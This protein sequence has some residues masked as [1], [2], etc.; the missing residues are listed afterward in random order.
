MQ[1]VSIILHG[2]SSSGKTS[3]A[4]ALQALWPTPLLH[5]DM[6][7]FELMSEGTRLPTLEHRR[8]A[9]RLHCANLQATL[10]NI[11]ATQFSLV[12]DFV[13]RDSGQFTRCLD[14]LSGRCVHVVG[15]KCDLEVLEAR[16][17]QR[18]D[19]DIGLSRSQFAH[20]EYSRNYDL[21]IDTTR[22]TAHEA[23]KVIWDFAV[24]RQTLPGGTSNGTAAV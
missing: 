8:E 20:P 11:A 1:P 7:A 12:L 13:L 14:A 2:P 10:R 16:E 6:D 24:A 21:V 3:L 4:R 23:A 15:V 22:L 18:G 9:F 19:R 17:R 5:V